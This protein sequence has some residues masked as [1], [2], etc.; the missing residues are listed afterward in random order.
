VGAGIV[1]ERAGLADAIHGE[2][3]R[4]I[5]SLAYGPGEMIFENVVAA[6]FGVSRTPVRQAFFRL[7]QEELL[8]V[9]PQRGARVSPLSVAK[10]KEAQI[11]REVLEIHA[12]GEVARRW[13]PAA[14]ACRR[15]VADIKA[16]IAAQKAS[17]ARGDYMTFI[18]LDEDYHNLVLG[19][20]GNATLIAV[21]AG[22]RAH[23]TRLRYLELKEAHHEVEAIA[24]HEQILDSLR[25]GDA[26]ATTEQLRAHLKMLETFR[27]EL[28][29]RHAGLFA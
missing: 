19:L 10:V 5:I 15:A 29:R 8:Q 20:D 3:R 7:A 1:A 23:L 4:R 18:G 12:F 25:A 14:P 21:I 24:Y 13:N 9:L 6:E 11:V 22:V 27:E 26:G 28:F 2:L 17:V 16:C